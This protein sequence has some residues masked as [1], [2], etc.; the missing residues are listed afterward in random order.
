M[1]EEDLAMLG[2]ASTLSYYVRT[3][4]NYIWFPGELD[5]RFLQRI[6]SDD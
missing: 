3:P 6:S 2:L 1:I 5:L 4:L